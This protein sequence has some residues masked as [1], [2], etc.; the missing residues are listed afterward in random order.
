MIG[1][2]LTDKMLR[3]IK[4][5]EWQEED[6]KLAKNLGIEGKLLRKEMPL[7]TI[8]ALLHDAL[9]YRKIYLSSNDE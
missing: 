5:K 9:E 1:P 4:I 6:A 2:L 7:A 8:E 3:S